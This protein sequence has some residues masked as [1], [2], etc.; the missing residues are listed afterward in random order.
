MTYTKGPWRVVNCDVH[1]TAENDGRR[2]IDIRAGEV[3]KSPC[4]DYVRGYIDCGGEQIAWC[5]SS[6][7]DDA[8]LIAAAPELVEALRELTEKV[9]A[10]AI[11]RARALLARI[12][13]QQP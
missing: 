1:P 12:E 2:L 7:H 8:R 11:N 4:P 3:V 10:D 5:T 13:G 6:T 9:S